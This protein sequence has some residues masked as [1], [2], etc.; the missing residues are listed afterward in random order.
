[1]SNLRSVMY[2]KSVIF[3]SKA[4]LASPNNTSLVETS[5][6][7]RKYRR[8]CPNHSCACLNHTCL[9]QN[10]TQDVKFTFLCVKSKLVDVKLNAAYTHTLVRV[11]S[12]FAY[13]NNTYMCQ[14]HIFSVRFTTICVKIQLKVS[15]SVSKV[16]F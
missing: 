13:Q 10:Y 12:H 3:L 14:N 15:M 7:Y 4:H 5:Y 9:R 8:A 1:V 16:D 11:N 6:E 2:R